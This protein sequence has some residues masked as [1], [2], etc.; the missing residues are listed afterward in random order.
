M[1]TFNINISDATTVIYSGYLTKSPPIASSRTTLKRWRRRFFVLHPN[2]TI[3]YYDSSSMNTLKGAIDLRECIHI[4]VGLFYKKRSN[5]ICLTTLRRKFFFQANSNVEM[6][7]WANIVRTIKATKEGETITLPH[8]VGVGGNMEMGDTFQETFPMEKAVATVAPMPPVGSHDNGPPSVGNSKFL[9]IKAVL[10]RN[11]SDAHRTQPVISQQRPFVSP[12]THH[13]NRDSKA[14]TFEPEQRSI[15]VEQTFKKK[16]QESQKRKKKGDVKSGSGGRQRLP[17]S[18][19]E[20]E[21]FSGDDLENDQKF[22]G[23]SLQSI[24]DEAEES[25]VCESEGG[26]GDQSTFARNKR[27]SKKKVKALSNGKAP[28]FS[29]SDDDEDEPTDKVLFKAKSLENMTYRD[30]G[31]ESSPTYRIQIL[32]PSMTH[33]PHSDTPTKMASNIEKLEFLAELP[34]SV[35][36]THYAAYPFSYSGGTLQPGNSDITLHVPPG[37]ISPYDSLFFPELS[38][39]SMWRPLVV[40]NTKTC[41]DATTDMP[42]FL[43]VTP[44]MK[45]TPSRDMVGNQ[46]PIRFNHPITLKFP[47]SMLYL[48][49]A[50]SEETQFA[51]LIAYFTRTQQKEHNK[52]KDPVSLCFSVYPVDINNPSNV[53]EIR[54]LLRN[55]PFVIGMQEKAMMVYAREMSVPLWIVGGVVSKEK[56]GLTDS[57]TLNKARMYRELLPVKC[58]QLKVFT[59][60]SVHSNQHCVVAYLVEDYYDAKRTIEALCYKQEFNSCVKPGEESR[61]ELPLD[62]ATPITAS[63]GKAKGQ[64]YSIGTLEQDMVECDGCWKASVFYIQISTSKHNSHRGGGVV[65]LSLKILMDKQLCCQQKINLIMK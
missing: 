13:D 32:P 31:F 3:E 30:S 2:K 44:L 7:Y 34:S 61:L 38:A 21:F 17:S 12:P 64:G 5:V 60:Y 51:V 54:E 1:A 62:T 23:H 48:S 4:E 24:H 22:G 16:F 19:D 10:S 49:Q 57:Q 53:T 52:R 27:L 26:G 65:G 35:D 41:D 50:R 15:V 29:D 9:N 40:V 11:R 63:I 14:Y 56:I 42:F 36:F 25:E 18:E 47:H 46:Q 37:A 55:K 33:P 58:Y 28:H 39:S 8:L 43:P 20:F 6:W 45:L 59:K